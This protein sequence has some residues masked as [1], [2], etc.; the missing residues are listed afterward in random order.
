MNAAAHFIQSG[1]VTLPGMLDA[2]A[3][4]AVDT[5][6]RDVGTVGARQM[7][8]LDWCAV[9]ADKVRLQLVAAGLLGA[10]HVSVQCTYFE[11]SRGH[12][13][14]VVP[15]QDLSIPV[16]ARIHSNGLT[17]WSEKDGMLFVQPPLHVLESLVALRLHIDDCSVDDG[18]LK[19]VPGSHALGR[20][21]EADK[22]RLRADL[23]EVSCPVDAGGGMALRPLL[24]H[25]SSKA[26]GQS[27]RRVLHFV[28]GPPT[29]PL[30]LTWPASRQAAHL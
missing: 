6:L 20:L 8:Q 7:L 15:H 10:D 28:F 9:L 16:A 23:G 29:L 22:A 11:K 3:L 21:Q 27:R 5:A 4:A 19:V 2:S 30:G 1:H 26:T 14:L 25:A 17:G 12:N 13:W 18:V 24:L